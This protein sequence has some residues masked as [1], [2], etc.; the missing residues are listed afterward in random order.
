MKSGRTFPLIVVLLEGQTAPGLPFLRQLHWI[1]T[2]DP[3][4][5]KDIARIFDAASGRGAAPP[6]LWRYASP[7][8][9]LEAME[10]KDSDYFF[11]RTRETI[12]ALNALAAPG[13]LPVLIGNSGVGKSS[14]AQAG[15]LAAL[16][17]QAWPDD[18]RRVRRLAGGLPEQP[19]MVLPDAQARRRAASRRWSIASSTHGSSTR[20]IPKRVEAADRA[21]SSFCAARRR[22]S[23]LIDATERRSRGTQPAGA[24]GLFS[25]RRSGRGALCAR[26]GARAAAILRT[27]WRRR[28]ADPRLRAMMSMRSD[29]LGSLQSDT[30][31][32]KARLLIDV[33]PL[34][35]DGLRE[36]VS[37]PAK[38]LGARFESERLIDIIVRAPPRIWSRTWGRCRS[39][40]TRSTT[41]GREM[42]KAG[43][44]VLRLPCSPFELA[45][46]LVD[47]AE[48]VS[49]RASGRGGRAEAHPHAQARDRARGRRAD[50]APRLSRRVLGRELAARLR[51][52]RPSQPAARHRHDRG[53]RDL[54]RG[55]ARDDLPALGEAQGM[56]RR[57][58]RV[59]RSGAA[60]WRRAR[61]AWEKTPDR[62]KNDALL[63]GFALTQA[64]GWL[65]RRADGH[66]GGRTDVHRAEPQD[67]RSDASA[68]RRRSSVPW[69]LRWPRAAWPGGTRIS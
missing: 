62:D 54:R 14:L 40:P 10:E 30:P 34:G 35:E 45:G 58:A 23:D 69:L 24:A 41:C 5:E 11:G 51:A 16:K 46:V 2:P 37:R 26:R 27:H 60:A 4:S 42:L 8:R 52:F 33:P 9:G 65:A 53:R 48:A 12:E 29:F 36:V 67:R 15:V 38:L 50:A 44:G 13:R 17:R 25:L 57:R 6:E 66:S 1:V 49:R 63:M 19:A 28:F 18:A 31:L 32:F 56:D 64:Q 55:G 59:P 43:D 3:A 68:A 39:S 21:G 61:R 7:Y 47:R 22:S 20:P